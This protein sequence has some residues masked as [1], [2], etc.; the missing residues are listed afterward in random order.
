MDS[1]TADSGQMRVHVDTSATSDSL[2]DNRSIPQD[3]LGPS[4]LDS[5]SSGATG[6]S[7]STATDTTAR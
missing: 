3:T 1:V 4:N 7:D 5:T 6:W 2:R